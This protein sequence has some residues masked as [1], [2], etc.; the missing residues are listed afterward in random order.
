MMNSVKDWLKKWYEENAGIAEFQKIE[1]RL[2]QGEE[3]SNKASLLIEFRNWLA[4]FTVW[5]I[6]TT[7][8]I[9]VDALTQEVV[10]NRDE[11]YST[12]QELN[13]IIGRAINELRQ[14]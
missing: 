5:K 12:E 9:V 7:E 3:E 2:P 4:S 11:E 13:Q 6:G 14:L 10:T 1:L 8:W